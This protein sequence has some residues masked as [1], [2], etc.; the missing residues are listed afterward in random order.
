MPQ[1]A[2]NYYVVSVGATTA[3]IDGV[4]TWVAGDWLR[5]RRRLIWQRVQNSTGPYVPLVGG[6]ISPGPLT[7]ATG[8][9]LVSEPR[10]AGISLGF[11]DATG[12]FSAYIQPDGTFRVATMNPTA[13][14]GTIGGTASL[15]LPQITGSTALTV[16]SGAT[17]QQVDPRA[18]ATALPS[19][20]PPAMWR[21]ASIPMVR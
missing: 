11:S 21:S 10:N 13:L 16:T 17:L 8:G 5:C 3:A 6:T 2:G 4:T 14:A 19:P 7:I 20:M 18:P 12:N 9:A 15:T 1:T